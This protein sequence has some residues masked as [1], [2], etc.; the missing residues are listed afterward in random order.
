MTDQSINDQWVI[1]QEPNE[2]FF[3][4]AA[5]GA[6][7]RWIFLAR[8]VPDRRRDGQSVDAAD[9]LADLQKGLVFDDRGVQPCPEPSSSGQALWP[10]T[11]I[12]RE[13]PHS[14][15]AEGPIG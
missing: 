12:C 7:F 11:G 3:P 1:P 6:D 15:C 5:Q 14:V 8:C 10:K 2:S 4:H 9:K 13:S